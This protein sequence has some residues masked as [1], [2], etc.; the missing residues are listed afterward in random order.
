MKIHSNLTDKNSVLKLEAL[1][2]E[3]GQKGTL[4]AGGNR[5]TIK[6]FDFEGR[7]IT[8]KSFKIPNLVNKIVYKYFRKS[9]AQRSFEY[10]SK[11]LKMNVGTPHPIA[12]AEDDQLLFNKSYYA[13]D[14]LHFDLM[15]RDLVEDP[16]YAGET[17]IL[18][19]FTEFTHGLHEKGIHFLDHSPGNT[20]IVK[21]QQGY[22]FY[23]VDLN[24]MEFKPMDYATRIK[25]FSRLTPK[26]EMVVIMATEYARLAG[27][28]V[29]KT[30]ADMWSATEDFQQ[31]FQRKKHLKKK[32]KFWKK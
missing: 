24:R 7:I 6:N 26:K 16:K 22:S 31:Q 4:F 28:D 23:L 2:T 14:L 15:Y 5:N 17:E 18:T 21:E 25:N 13:C 29:Q 8:I 30:I 1:L 9:K 32:L 27:Y 3:F 19:A 12:Y 10:A 20:L 11:L